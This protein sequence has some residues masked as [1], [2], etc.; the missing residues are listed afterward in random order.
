[1]VNCNGLRLKRVPVQLPIN[2]TTL[3]LSN[4]SL[5]N[6]TDQM[7]QRF[8]HLRLLD[9]SYNSIFAIHD[10]ALHGISK[11]KTLN[12]EFNHLL[13]DSKT[14]HPNMFRDLTEL[15]E[16]RIVDNDNDTSRP[17]ATY[18]DQTL[19]HLTSLK[20]LHLDGLPADFGP[21]FSQMRNL[22]NLTLSGYRKYC[23]LPVLQNTTFSN[24]PTVHLL[25][26]SFCDVKRTDLLTFQPLKQIHLI[27]ISDNERLSFDNLTNATYGLQHS[28]LQV[29]R[30]NRPLR[31]LR[32]LRVL[33]LSYN[34]LQRM[35]PNVFEKDNSLQKL[36]L[37]HNHL[38][39]ALGKDNT[40]NIFHRLGEIQHLDLSRNRITFL[41]TRIF[42]G[43]TNAKT[44]NLS[45]NYLKSFHVYLSKSITNLSLSGNQ[46]QML[47]SRA[48]K[49]FDKLPELV[50]NLEFNP[51]SCTCEGLYF[52]R[53]LSK[54]KHR[55][56]GIKR[57]SCCMKSDNTTDSD[58]NSLDEIIGI[59]DKRCDGVN[60]M[61]V[62]VSLSVL[63][64][65]LG[66][67][68]V[69]IGYRHRW[70]LRYLYHVGRRGYHNKLA[71]DNE[72]NDP[73]E[74]DVFV[75]YAEPDRR[76]VIDTMMPEL[77]TKAELR[78]C[79]HDRDFLPGEVIAT[80]IV[81]AIQRS[82]KTLVVLS[83]AFLKSHWCE[84]EYNMARMEG[85][86]RRQN[87]VIIVLY[88]YVKVKDLPKD[89][90]VMLRNN[91]YLEYSEEVF[92]N[93]VFWGNVVEAIKAVRIA[94]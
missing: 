53:W 10:N 67:I 46:I 94:D 60:I 28:S 90:V 4:N 87:I 3:L 58:T 81:D 20:V 86:S 8:P 1:M 32:N 43:L 92:G 18:P 85:V 37:H 52:L 63:I 88:E 56:V 68:F 39:I 36:N 83:P 84:F 15:E 14:Y 22:R 31:G 5:T 76:F 2:T 17:H 91:S 42:R 78:M 74:Y 24:V 9:L 59:L 6:L 41:P 25:N 40:G 7:F 49:E 65:L 54:N 30:A 26:I 27:D 38:G 75:S 62:S 35:R 82:R 48:L 23:K 50:L 16:L 47:S 34:G 13:L 73:F 70:T 66:V 71:V 72:S 44:I 77:E 55:V 57:M 80:N 93:V 45:N 79:I 21:G 51:I 11:L 89:M 12:L 64:L 61:I 29:L 33:D 19:K 69:A